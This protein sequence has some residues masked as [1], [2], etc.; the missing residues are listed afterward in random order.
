MEYVCQFFLSPSEVARVCLAS[1]N[2][3]FKHVLHKK[4]RLPVL[5]LAEFLQENLNVV[6]VNGMHVYC[7]NG[8]IY[9][10]YKKNYLK[11]DVATMQPTHVV[12]NNIKTFNHMWRLM[13]SVFLELLSG[14]MLITYDTMC[15]LELNSGSVVVVP[16]NGFAVYKDGKVQ[17]LCSSVK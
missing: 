14:D 10:L 6:I 2:D 4:T 15:D 8:Y 11:I 7:S 3:S 12:I 1:T 17:T 13:H 5:C 9:T 16:M